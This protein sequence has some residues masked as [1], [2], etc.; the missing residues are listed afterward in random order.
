MK[1]VD[2][3]LL[4]RL[5]T[6]NDAMAP[7]LLLLLDRWDNDLDGGLPPSAELR[8]LGEDFTALGRDLITRADEVDAIT[9]H[10]QPEIN[11]P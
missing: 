3:R 7:V 1:A 11:Q 5:A 9:Q 8:S 2:A 6:V 10:T 4:R